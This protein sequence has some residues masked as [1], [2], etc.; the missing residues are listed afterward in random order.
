M[1]KPRSRRPH[2]RAASTQLLPEGV[3]V[4]DV[5]DGCRTAV[6][7]FLDGVS[8]GWGK[9][10]LAHWLAGPYRSL[11]SLARHAGMMDGSPRSRSVTDEASL[12]VH[13]LSALVLS[14]RW[15]LLAAFEGAIS[16]DNNVSFANAAL[17]AGH[18]TRCLDGEGRAGWAPFN[19]PTMRLADR[20][21][22]LVAADYL[23]RPEDY[24]TNLSVCRFCERV[25]FDLDTKKRGAC[26]AHPRTHLSG[27]RPRVDPTLHRTLRSM[28]EVPAAPAVPG[29]GK[30][31]R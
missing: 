7:S 1:D 23:V 20:V 27:M 17:Y 22:S 16:P 15:T 2:P 31:R 9:A 24:E 18:V 19:A 8:A 12:D 14:V 11:T 3:L 30:S 21:L 5:A 13:R 6:L 29:T 25:S 10:E 28:P 4:V 26:Q